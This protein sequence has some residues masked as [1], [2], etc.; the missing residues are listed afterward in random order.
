MDLLEELQITH[1]ESFNHAVEINKPFKGLEP[2]LC[3]CRSECR[4]HWKW[5]LVDTPS[6]I[7]NGRYIFYFMDEKDYFAFQLKW[8]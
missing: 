4:G 3:W 8:G 2:I 6:D 7:R 1:G 5:Q